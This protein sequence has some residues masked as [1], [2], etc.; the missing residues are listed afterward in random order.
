MF[1]AMNQCTNIYIL[2]L[3]KTPR[4]HSTGTNPLRWLQFMH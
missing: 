3:V 2:Y 4:T 1:S